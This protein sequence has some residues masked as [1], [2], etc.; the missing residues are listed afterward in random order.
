MN[1]SQRNENQKTK[2]E[3]H[4]LG[5]TF[6]ADK[7]RRDQHESVLAYEGGSAL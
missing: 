5:S 6:S 1:V 7:A 3:A 4:K 2:L